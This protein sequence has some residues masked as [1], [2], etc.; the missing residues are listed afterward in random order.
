VTYEIGG[1]A[2]RAELFA[3][4]LAAYAI[5]IDD[6]L[7]PFESESGRTAFRNAGRSRRLGLEL[8]WQ[9]R[10]LAPLRWSG[11]VTL[12]DAK[13]RDYTVGDQSFDGNDEPGIPSYW[14]YQELA[15]L[16][17]GGLFAAVEAFL[18]DGY[19]VNDANTASTD[20]YALVNLRAGYQ[21]TS[22][23][24]GPWPPSSASTISPT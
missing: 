22:P 8:D 21:H 2:E 3:A 16:G 4:G 11:A 6:E 7:V 24:A 15:Y 1:R 17:P 23:N 13:Y 9:V 12:L 18:V 14:I 20:S 10:L 5:A 19:F